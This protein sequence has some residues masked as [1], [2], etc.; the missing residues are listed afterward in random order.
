MTLCSIASIGLRSLCSIAAREREVISC[1][2][3]SAGRSGPDDIVVVT[4]CMVP[5]VLLF[6]F[7]K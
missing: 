2:E 5:L 1:W 6:K 4:V 3:S 7:D